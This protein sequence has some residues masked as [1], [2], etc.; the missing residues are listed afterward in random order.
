MTSLNKAIQDAIRDG[1]LLDGKKLLYY[2]KYGYWYID[3]GNND[4]DIVCLN[5]IL[6]DPLF[7]QCLGKSRGWNKT[8]SNFSKKKITITEYWRPVWHR[9]IDHLADGKDITSFF[10]SL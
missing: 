2:E 1:Y 7:W 9:L 10:D 3:N 6:L 8:S 4:W 5:E